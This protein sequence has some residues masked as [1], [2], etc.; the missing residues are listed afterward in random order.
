METN[1][2]DLRAK[3]EAQLSEEKQKIKRPNILLLGNTGVGKSSL[4]NTIF[5]GELAKICHTRPETRGFHT[6]S[7][8]DVPVNIIDSEGYELN[9][10]S[11]F[12]RTL[13]DFISR[14]FTDIEKQIH[15]CWYCI[16]I[17]SRRVLPYD[18]EN[19]RIL[20]EKKIPTCVVFTQCDNDDPE[21][22]VAKTLAES[23]HKVFGKEVPCFQTSNDV[24]INKEL[25]LD[26][27]I[28]WSVENISDDNLRLGFIAA[29]RVSLKQKDDKA[30]TRIKFYATGAAGVG[31]SPIP[32]SDAVLLTGLQVTMAADLYSIYGIDNSVGRIL[33][34]VIQGKVVSMIGKMLA[35]NLAKLIPGIGSAIG[36]AIN[37][38]VAGAITYGMGRAIAALCHKAV[39]DC[40][41]GNNAALEAIFTADNLN[42]MFDKYYE[43]KD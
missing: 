7:A 26:K 23:V 40:W 10:D 42:K 22:S 17:S 21:G 3:F 8:P 13:E 39:E 4:V 18:L 24:E 41:D 25:D 15:I 11:D 1:E 29:Q 33:Q 9:D 6:Y 36:G 34:N 38:A 5:G 20:R 31:A 32:C 35:G 43:K 12:R 2:K 30:A 28:D 14:N 27:L 16:S 19:I 37:A